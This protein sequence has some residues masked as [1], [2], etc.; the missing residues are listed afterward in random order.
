[1]KAEFKDATGTMIMIDS[2][3]VDS[4]FDD[5]LAALDGYTMSVICRYSVPEGTLVYG[6]AAAVHH[7]LG[8]QKRTPPV[9]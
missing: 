7:K 1:M 8:L 5:S 3:D 6:S 4:V 9:E 2:K